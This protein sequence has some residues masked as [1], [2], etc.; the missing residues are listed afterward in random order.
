MPVPSH[1]TAPLPVTEPLNSMT[2]LSLAVSV[3]PLLMAN[4]PGLPLLSPSIV[5]SAPPLVSIGSRW[6]VRFLVISSSP[7]VS[8]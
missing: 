6:M 8:V 4:T 7:A 2:S 5:I 1:V 3:T